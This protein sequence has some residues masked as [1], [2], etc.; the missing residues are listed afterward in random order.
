MGGLSA[1]QISE[2]LGITKKHVSIIINSGSF[3][4]ELAMRRSSYTDD[5]DEKV[6]SIEANVVEELKKNAIK[7]ASTLVNGLESDDERIKFNS[8]ESILDR[9]GHHKTT[10]QIE[11]NKNST[12]VVISND[13]LEN[14]N[15]TSSILEKDNKKQANPSK[16]D[17]HRP[18]APLYEVNNSSRLNQP[19]GEPVSFPKPPTSQN[20]QGSGG[21]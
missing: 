4:H 11:E 14:I 12:I 15:E 21:P 10:R 20:D 19:S 3:Q 1:S 6:A 9:T 5:F 2:K 13:D 18:Q 8:A 17:S 7:A 16:Y